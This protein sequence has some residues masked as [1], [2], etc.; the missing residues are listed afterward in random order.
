M[1]LNTGSYSLTITAVNAGA[2]W[3][4]HGWLLQDT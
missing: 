2:A 1:L 4:H 3:W